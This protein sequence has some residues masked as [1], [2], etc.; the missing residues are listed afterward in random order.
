M[1]KLIDDLFTFSKLDLNQLPMNPEVVKME[2]FIRNITEEMELEY[3]E[4]ASVS[5]TLDNPSERRC[6]EIDRYR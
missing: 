2:K 5:M 1:E 3:Q 6:C 4:D